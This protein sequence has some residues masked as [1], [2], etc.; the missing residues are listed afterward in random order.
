[1]RPARYGLRGD[2]GMVALAQWNDMEGFFVG[3]ESVH[4]AYENP[5][6]EL[7]TVRVTLRS[8]DWLDAAP[9]RPTRTLVLGDAVLEVLGALGH[10]LGD[11]AL[12]DTELTVPAGSPDATLTARVGSL[13]HVGGEWAWDQWQL[14]YPAR[15]GVWSGLPVGEREAWL[16]VAGIV[17]FR[18]RRAQYPTLRAQHDIDGSHID[19]LASFFCAVGE[20]LAGPGGYCGSNFAD[21]SDCVRYAPREVARPRLVW[22]EIAVAEKALPALALAQSV[23]AEGGIDVVPS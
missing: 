11:Y 12:L 2:D 19:D 17:A 20:A 21:L 10:V 15:P 1:M 13:P 14:G 7:Q 8:V 9:D 4:D 22:H 6:E 23:F 3:R 16:E 5:P 18:E